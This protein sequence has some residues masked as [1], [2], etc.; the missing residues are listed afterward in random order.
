M[1][2]NFQI[3]KRKLSNFLLQPLLQTKIGLYCI[4]LSLVFAALVAWILYSNLGELFEFVI[5]MTDAPDEM[6]KIIYR[7]MKSMVIGIY[8]L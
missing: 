5:E 7:E 3:K 1:S 6:H 2:L 8:V 4:G